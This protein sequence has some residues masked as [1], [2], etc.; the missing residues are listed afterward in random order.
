MEDRLKKIVRSVF[1][2]GPSG[3]LDGLVYKDHPRWDS[4]GHIQLI[5]SLEK[6]FRV[7]FSSEDVV[8]VRTLEDIASLLRKKGGQAS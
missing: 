7:K 1:N 3:S 6:E 5:L 4:L 2:L 8:S